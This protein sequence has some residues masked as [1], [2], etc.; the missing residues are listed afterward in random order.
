MSKLTREEVLKIAKLARL[1]LTPAEVER[2]QGQ[3]GRVLGYVEELNS[4]KTGDSFVRHVPKDAVAFREDMPLAFPDIEA[5]MANSPQTES[6]HFL[7]P[8]IIE[9]S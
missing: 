2:Y 9:K 6:N 7:L 3:L 1:E 8:P 4:L 5:L